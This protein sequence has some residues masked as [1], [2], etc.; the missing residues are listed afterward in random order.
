MR[1]HV[2]G[3]SGHK[4][5]YHCAT[6][7][8]NWQEERRSFGFVDPAREPLSYMTVY[9]D[10][11]RGTKTDEELANAKPPSCFHENALPELLFYHNEITNPPKN[12]L[13]V[14]ELSYTNAKGG[15]EVNTL[16][17]ILHKEGVSKKR[18]KTIAIRREL[19]FIGYG[20]PHEGSLLASKGAT[21]TPLDYTMRC[22]TTT[23][24][25]FLESTRGGCYK[26]PVIPAIG[27]MQEKQRLL[28]TKNV[29]VD[30]TGEYLKDNIDEY[31]ATSSECW[32]MFMKFTD[33]MKGKKLRECY[34]D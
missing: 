26:P 10:S 24:Q 22:G 29:T 6:L 30:A 31:P 15:E 1:C 27:R 17:D 32:G 18:D 25:N 8:G 9:K 21:A 16:H 20:A 3:P 23:D 14:N 28:T 19:G 33:N 2:M 12:L 7:L 11:F 34:E 4:S 5:E 13:T